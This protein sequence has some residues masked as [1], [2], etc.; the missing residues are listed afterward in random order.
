MSPVSAAVLATDVIHSQTQGK[1]NKLKQFGLHKSLGFIV[2][3]AA[4]IYFIIY[5]LSLY[6]CMLFAC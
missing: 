4:S 1:S 2:L 3:S 6:L 5:L